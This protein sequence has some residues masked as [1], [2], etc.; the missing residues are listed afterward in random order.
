M[1]STPYH[2]SA[3]EEI[4]GMNLDVIHAHTEFGVGIFARMVAKDLNIPVVSTYHTMYED[5]THYIN[6]FELEGVEK[7]TRKVAASFSR[8]I[9]DTCEGVIAPS[10]KTKDTL[11]KYGVNVQIHIIPT[12][13]DL[14]KFN[15]DSVDPRLIEEVKERY[16]LHDGDKIML[17][18]GRIAEE[19]SIDV[20]IRGYRKALLQHSNYKMIIVG[21]GPDLDELRALC[22]ELQITSQ[23]IF[24][25]KQPHELVP[26]FYALAD[27]FVS[28]SLTETQGM[29]FVEALSS[30]LP[31]FARR[32]EV[33]LD[34]IDE[35]LSGYYVNEQNF[36]DVATAYFELDDEQKQKMKVYARNKALPYDCE[37]F[38]QDVMKVYE[39][40]INSY[41]RTLEIKKVKTMDDC[42]QLTCE[43]NQKEEIKVLL[44]V[45]DYFA[46]ELKKNGMLHESTLLELKN[47]RR[48]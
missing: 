19:K 30:G 33:L 26:V 39:E 43:N 48:S 28:F 47:V 45:D 12:G 25:D 11:L 42:V 7:I 9:T 29:T 20:A 6:K 18:V 34:L 36:S 41:H 2:F 46:F 38:Y 44:S 10:E 4:R 31:V 37:T 21:G 13:L 14:K 27:A 24:T 32:D 35:G 3:K 15:V 1:L 5:Y 23:V 17:Y 8:I 40:A 16:Q 22:E